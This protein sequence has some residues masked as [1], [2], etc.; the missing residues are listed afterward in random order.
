MNISQLL[1]SGGSIQPKALVEFLKPLYSVQRSRGP[2]EVNSNVQGAL[3]PS[4]LDKP[5]RP[6]RTLK[7]VLNTTE[8]NPKP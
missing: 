3:E 1:L 5:Y 6:Y 8:K 2:V 4:W 7:Q